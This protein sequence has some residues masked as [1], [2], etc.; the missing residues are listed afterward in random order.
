[1]KSRILKVWMIVFCCVLLVVGAIGAIFVQAEE[2]YFSAANL[3]EVKNRTEFT[4]HFGT[5]P[6]DVFAERDSEDL[7]TTVMFSK[8]GMGSRIAKKTKVQIDGFTFRMDYSNIRP[9]HNIYLIFTDKTNG[10]PQ[11]VNTFKGF[12]IRLMRGNTGV[13]GMNDSAKI[14]L[15]IGKSHDQSAANAIYGV[16]GSISFDYREDG[17]NSLSFSIALAEDNSKYVFSVSDGVSEQNLDI[18][19]SYI[20]EW[21][22]SG[23]DAISQA[24]FVLGYSD[25]PTK[26]N[27]L[28]T[29]DYPT[30]HITT[31][32]DALKTQYLTATFA[33]EKAKVD[34]YTSAANK[35]TM[36]AAEILAAEEE[37]E[38]LDVS[39]LYVEDQYLVS[40]IRK[41]ADDNIAASI[42]GLNAEQ[43]NILLDEQVS[44][45]EAI[46]EAEKTTAQAIIDARAAKDEIDLRGIT[47]ENQ[48]ETVNLRIS[49]AMAVI[50]GQAKD[51]VEGQIE[52]LEAVVA[53][54]DSLAKYTEAY[55]SRETLDLDLL[56]DANAHDFDTRLAAIDAA[57]ETAE[58]TYGTEFVLA[59]A[60]T[61]TAAYEEAYEEAKT[62]EELNDLAVIEAVEALRDAIQF[63]GIDAA[64]ETRVALEAR[65]LVIDQGLATA[66]KDI[67]IAQITAYEQAIALITDEDTLA[68]AKACREAVD[69]TILPDDAL[70]PEG[71]QAADL[72]ARFDAAEADYAQKYTEL[73]EGIIAGI[74]A[75]FN[76]EVK[77]LKLYEEYVK[78]VE[79]FEIEL[80]PEAD[81]AAFEDRLEA[82]QAKID[83]H[84]YADFKQ[85]NLVGAV[86]TD[87]GLQM[88]SMLDY[89]ARVNYN[90]PVNVDGFEV[91]YTMD[92]FAYLAPAAGD[93]ARSN[94][95]IIN[96]LN[97]P[98]AF[99]AYEVDGEMVEG[100]SVY[101]WYYSGTTGIKVYSGGDNSAVIA[102]SSLAPSTAPALMKISITAGEHGWVIK[103][104][105]AECTVLYPQ[106][107]KDVFTDGQAYFS[108]GFNGTTKAEDVLDKATI[109][110]IGNLVLGE[111]EEPQQPGNNDGDD[112][113]NQ[114]N[115]GIIPDGNNGTD[116][117]PKG[118]CSGALGVA[119]FALAISTVLPAVYILGKRS[120]SRK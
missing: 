83:E 91:I 31:L 20:R 10:F 38:T 69:F 114:Q 84:V 22:A 39:K 17:E 36:T 105:S 50:D 23:S 111:Y 95:A 118:G 106:I 14:Y 9:Q 59:R 87:G 86:M 42:A 116:S 104:N 66:R 6:M 96:L 19:E 56:A 51:F 89:G 98:N 61:A 35:N 78:T 30:Y 32:S 37:I 101:V 102:Q 15:T 46:A 93:G 2:D 107:S 94:A 70:L 90:V 11:P 55:E 119:S 5:S 100:I 57:L 67:V 44:A 3:T 92:E 18:S 54:I 49:A 65:I 109:H 71:S 72:Q 117:E 80:L 82:L 24:F 81:R 75:A 52:K 29:S 103:A 34:A 53:Q 48:L 79:E 110:K 28:L 63:T 68:D 25:L 112:N 8:I 26:P 58:Q 33:P 13:P 4:N 77:D 74:E 120:K 88:T 27:T 7:S 73:S 99:K 85:T 45:F 21:F 43:V 108:M 41:A 115:P 97:K 62:N 76:A 113:D 47:D 64:D 16:G 1:M 60:E 12:T 40:Q